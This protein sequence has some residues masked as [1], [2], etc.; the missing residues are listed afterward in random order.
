MD[1]QNFIGRSVDIVD[2]YVGPDGTVM[3]ELKKYEGYIAGA[4]T[5][6]LAV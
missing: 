1:P 6:T 3:K 5:S 2:R 4:E